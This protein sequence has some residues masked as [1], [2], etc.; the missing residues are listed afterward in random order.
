MLVQG[1]W[2]MSAFLAYLE[3][4]LFHNSS[5]VA[6]EEKGGRDRW[7]GQR[8]AGWGRRGRDQGQGLGRVLK[9]WMVGDMG[10]KPEREKQGR[11][12]KKP[13]QFCVSLSQYKK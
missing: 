7:R 3:R 1:P 5:R 8:K 9:G 4:F 11:E 13:G 6:K 2:G 12:G 10:K